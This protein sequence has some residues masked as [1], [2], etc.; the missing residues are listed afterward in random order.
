MREIFVSQLIE[1]LYQS[2]SQMSKKPE[3]TSK[4]PE[5]NAALYLLEPFIVSLR[6]QKMSKY[7]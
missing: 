4:I 1:E 3:R 7:T 2:K 5:N 6:N